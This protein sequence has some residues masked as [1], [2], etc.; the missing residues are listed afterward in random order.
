MDLQQGGKVHFKVLLSLVI[1]AKSALV[2]P[3]GL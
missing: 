1:S 3:F 2:Y